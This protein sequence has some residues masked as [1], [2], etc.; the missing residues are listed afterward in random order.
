[1]G[2]GST[3]QATTS[4]SNPRHPCRIDSCESKGGN[5]S[6]RRRRVSKAW[7]RRQMITRL[8]IFVYF[9]TLLTGDVS[10]EARLSKIFHQMRRFRIPSNSSISIKFMFQ[11]LISP[12]PSPTPFQAKQLSPAQPPLL[13]TELSSSIFQ[14]HHSL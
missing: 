9:G 1:M 6:L 5:A 4:H 12:C 8:F 10:E 13:G 7:H 14:A 3:M 11:E 2:A